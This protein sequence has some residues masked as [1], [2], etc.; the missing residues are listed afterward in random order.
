MTASFKFSREC[1]FYNF[2]SVKALP[3]YSLQLQT[4]FT[5]QVFIF[6]IAV[7]SRLQDGCHTKK[8]TS[9]LCLKVD[10]VL[11]FFIVKLNKNSISPT[12]SAQLEGIF[13]IK[14]L[15][16][17]VNSQHPINCFYVSQR[18]DLKSILCFSC[19]W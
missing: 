16:K 12:I 1:L 15:I 6:Y 14:T 13:L 11:I 10:K 4:R 5:D 19:F 3:Y 2:P 8:M 18:N 17:N 9:V 7:R